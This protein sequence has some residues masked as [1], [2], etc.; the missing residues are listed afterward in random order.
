[1]IHTV[2]DVKDKYFLT[3]LNLFNTQQNPL[4]G[5]AI[6][7][8]VIVITIEN[9][10]TTGDPMVSRQTY[11]KVLSIYLTLHILFYTTFANPYN[12]VTTPVSTS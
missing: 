4:K 8:R 1:M 6:T 5:S 2:S 3:F 12:Q 11:L 10:K 7:D 9:K